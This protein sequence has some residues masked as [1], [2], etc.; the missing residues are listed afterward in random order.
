MEFIDKPARNI[1]KKGVTLYNSNERAVD[2]IKKHYL[3]LDL[4]NSFNRRMN[5]PL[6]PS[7]FKLKY[8]KKSFFS[9]KFLQMT[10]KMFSLGFLAAFFC[11]CFKGSLS[12]RRVL[13][14]E[15]FTILVDQ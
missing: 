6:T 5:H 2:Y 1:S 10:L 14:T 9:N 3:N 15:S 4:M 13:F 7:L 8:K 12:K 11:L